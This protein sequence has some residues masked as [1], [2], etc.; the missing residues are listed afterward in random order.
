MPLG[1]F[2]TNKN[3]KLTVQVLDQFTY[4]KF[5]YTWNTNQTGKT[6]N[7]TEPQYNIMYTKPGRYSTAVSVHAEVHIQEMWLE[8]KTKIGSKHEIITVKGKFYVAIFP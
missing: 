3:I 2:C 6:E 5:N 7:T 4:A 1:M 8:T